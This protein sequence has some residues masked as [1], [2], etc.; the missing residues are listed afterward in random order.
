[1]VL[2]QTTLVLFTVVLLYCYPSGSRLVAA[3]VSSYPLGPAGD[4][5]A[6]TLTFSN[7]ESSGFQCKNAVA[8]VSAVRRAVGSALQLDILL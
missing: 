7:K 2:P 1:M 4:V 6:Y 3:Q 8:V 5:F